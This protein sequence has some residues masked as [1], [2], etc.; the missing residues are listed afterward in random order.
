MLLLFGRTI[1]SIGGGIYRIVMS[2]LFFVSIR[3]SCWK[4]EWPSWVQIDQIHG[5]RRAQYVADA[6]YYYT[7]RPPYHFK[8]ANLHFPTLQCIGR[9]IST[10]ESLSTWE[11]CSNYVQH[12]AQGDGYEP[13]RADFI[14]KVKDVVN[15]AGFVL[16]RERFLHSTEVARKIPTEVAKAGNILCHP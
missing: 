3:P 8:D 9:E 10:P 14:Q 13:Q 2:K 16:Q 15:S 1:H 6:L 7:G 12:I 11:M 4:D 5:S